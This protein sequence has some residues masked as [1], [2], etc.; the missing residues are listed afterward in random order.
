MSMAVNFKPNCLYE[1]F[2]I[3]KYRDKFYSVIAIV[4]KSQYRPTLFLSLK[5]KSISLP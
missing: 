2:W 3:P 4:K 5:R 1:N